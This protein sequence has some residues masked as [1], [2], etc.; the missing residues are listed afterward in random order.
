MEGKK[1]P[2]SL[3]GDFVIFV[4]RLWYMLT[5]V[6]CHVVLERLACRRRKHGVRQLA[7]GKERSKVDVSLEVWSH[8]PAYA[9]VA[10]I[11]VAVD[12]HCEGPQSE[13]GEGVRLD[14]GPT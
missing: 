7:V 6:R 8:N 2:K 10:L 14:S 1:E 4:D 13:T 12:W 3:I 9:A 11:H 5:I